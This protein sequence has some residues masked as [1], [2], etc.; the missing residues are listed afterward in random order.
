M[1]KVL[2]SV[3]TLVGGVVGLLALLRLL[4][5]EW[6]EKSARLPAVMMQQMMAHMPDE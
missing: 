2:L 4:P 1:K 6:R 3:A 5:A